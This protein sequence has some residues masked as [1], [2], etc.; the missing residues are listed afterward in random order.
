MLILKE[1]DVKLL[2][3]YMVWLGQF[4]TDPTSLSF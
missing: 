4:D 3:R 2:W 1:L